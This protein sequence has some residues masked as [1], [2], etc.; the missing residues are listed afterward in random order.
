M[1]TNTDDR[2]EEDKRDGFSLSF[3][4]LVPQYFHYSAGHSFCVLC[5][6]DSCVLGYALRFTHPHPL[7]IVHSNGTPLYPSRVWL[8]VEISNPS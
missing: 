6:Y 4:I 8:S 3:E 2:R 5:S 7:T 1:Q